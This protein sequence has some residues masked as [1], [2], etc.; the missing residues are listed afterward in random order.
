MIPHYNVYLS[1]AVGMLT[2]VSCLV[3]VIF[4]LSAISLL[5]RCCQRLSEIGRERIN[6]N[7]QQPQ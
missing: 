4:I 6:G 5:S 7:S 2:G 1:L 3:G